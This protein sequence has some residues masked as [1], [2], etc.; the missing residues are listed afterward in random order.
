MGLK[1]KRS[2]D[3]SPS[4]STSSFLSSPS[5][6]STSPCPGP[7]QYYNEMEIEP[8]IANSTFLSWGEAYREPLSAR[9]NS[10]TR[11][12]A[13]D[14]RPD[15]EM[16]HGKMI[17]STRLWPCSMLTRDRKNVSET[18][19]RPTTTARRYHAIIYRISTSH[20]LRCAGPKINTPLL[21]ESSQCTSATTR[22][23]RHP[24]TRLREQRL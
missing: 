11:K 19:L 18:L 16:I 1:R 8:P 22:L 20:P 10:R 4:M 23:L 3:V 7:H 14:N 9:L 5:R 21:L 15:E 2:V 24:P 6:T 13:R 17:C 12:R